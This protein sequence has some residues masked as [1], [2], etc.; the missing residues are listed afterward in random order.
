MKLLQIL[1]HYLCVKQRK[2][3]TSAELKAFQAKALEKLWKKHLSHNPYFKSRCQGDFKDWPYMNKEIMLANFHWMNGAGITL[4]Q[5]YDEAM[6]AETSRD[7]KPTIEGYTIGLSSG[8][9]G[10]R[11]VFLLSPSEEKQWAGTILAKMLPGS[12]FKGERIAFFLRANSNLYETVQSRFISFKFF[13]LFQS[14][15]TQLSA[16]QEYQPT[17]LIAPAQV[18]E[19]IAEHQLDIH[20]IKVISVAEVLDD[21]TRKKI[22]RA[23]G[24]VHE[25]YQATEG[26]IASTCSHGH[27]HLNEDLMIIEQEMID[28]MRF[29]PIVT[30]LNRRTQPIIR[31]RLDDVLVKHPKPCP[32]GSPFQRIQ[33]IEGRLNDTLWLQ[34]HQGEKVTIF[35]DSCLRALARS[36]P[37]DCDFRL[38]QSSL[39]SLALTAPLS[40]AQLLVAQSALEEMFRMQNVDL[41]QLEW[42]LIAE[43]I[44]QVLSDKRRKIQ[45]LFTEE[46]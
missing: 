2:I 35:A 25:V 1:W 14:M 39:T 19:L 18:L 40:Q 12:L 42:Q 5:A 46:H 3:K 11:G 34:N 7:F 17:I 15:T 38:C 24:K 23:L 33:A 10:T 6:S 36:L 29:I 41:T 44:E 30:D 16:L 27:L 31:Y 26:F 8:T 28:D 32:C 21:A 4:A 37:F 9:S 43:P 45:R 20:P 22:E 13:D